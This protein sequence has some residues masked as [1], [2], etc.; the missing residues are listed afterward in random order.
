ML[1]LIPI[2]ASLAPTVASW[3]FGDKTGKAVETVS[4]IV[5]EQLGTDSPDAVQQAIASNPELAAQ[6]RLA[7]IKAEAE[8]RERQ[9]QL[10]REQQQ[11][12][13]D[14][15][16]AQLK[17]VQDARSQTVQLAQAH[18]PIA[19]GVV[20]VS[21]IVLLAFAAMLYFVIGRPTPQAESQSAQLLLGMLGTMATAVVSYWVGSSRGSE[22]KNALI[23]QAINGNVMPFPRTAADQARRAA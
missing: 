1:P 18:S 15:L 17:D 21:A 11:Q 16:L 6:L 3:I 2:L 19:W 7:L 20:V 13:H 4:T 5:R 8:E 9:A 10:L 22:Q 23:Q 14:E 12:Q